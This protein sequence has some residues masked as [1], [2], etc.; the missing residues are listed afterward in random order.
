MNDSAEDSARQDSGP[1]PTSEEKETPRIGF[2]AFAEV[3][4]TRWAANH[5]DMKPRERPTEQAPEETTST[6]GEDAAAEVSSNEGT[7]L[8]SQAMRKWR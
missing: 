4:R 6:L 5:P 1:S 2:R 8:A 3:Y 7:T